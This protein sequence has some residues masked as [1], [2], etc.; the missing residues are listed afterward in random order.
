[1]DEEDYQLLAQALEGEE[2]GEDDNVPAALSNTSKRGDLHVKNP[3]PPLDPDSTQ[4]PKRVK[5]NHRNDDTTPNDNDNSPQRN[6]ADTQS[7][8]LTQSPSD[9]RKIPGPAGSLPPIHPPTQPIPFPKLTSLPQDTEDGIVIQSK[10]YRKNPNAVGSSRDDYNTDFSRGAWIV[11]LKEKE[12]L[13]FGI[14]SISSII[15]RRHL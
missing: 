5:F 13:P 9:I 8:Q 14:P 3:P 12:L 11:M 1:M 15:H 10:L 6:S 4:P 2:E 7:S